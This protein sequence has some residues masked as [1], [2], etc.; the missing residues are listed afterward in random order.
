MDKIVKHNAFG[1]GRVKTLDDV[2]IEI[3]F[4]GQTKQ[5][6][7]PQGFDKFLV[8]EDPELLTKIEEAKSIVKEKAVAEKIKSSVTTAATSI[9]EKA[10]TKKKPYSKTVN[11]SNQLIGDR[12]QT[13]CVSSENEMFE[14]VGYMAKPGIVSSIEAEVPKDGR[15]KIFES[16]FPGQTYRPIE[17]GNTPS[18]MPNKLSPQFRI[19]FANLNNCPDVLKQNMGKGNGSCVGRINKS[20]FVI[21]IVQNYGFRFGARQNV[22]SIREIAVKR[23]YSSDFDR[24]YSR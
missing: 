20:K 12:A 18:G 7:F 10:K 2:H 22:Q 16:L 21:D 19:N 1:I 4:D 5:F 17:L 24:G 8:T 9:S 23:G 13:I 11:V 14:I 6:Q 3:E 15:D